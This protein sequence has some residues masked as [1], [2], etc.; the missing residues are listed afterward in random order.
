MEN[1]QLLSSYQLVETYITKGK[2]IQQTV[3][4]RLSLIFESMKIYDDLKVRDEVISKIGY[5]IDEI[6]SKISELETKR[7]SIFNV[8]VD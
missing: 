5:E 4:E 3:E 6:L 8:T 7:K 1:N 2:S